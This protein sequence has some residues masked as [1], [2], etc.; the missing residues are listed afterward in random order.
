MVYVYGYLV[1][2]LM[3]YV[4]YLT[5]F[6]VEEN[7]WVTLIELI[8]GSLMTIFLPILLL[9]RF[10]LKKLAVRK[11]KRGI[12]REV[13]YLKDIEDATGIKLNFSGEW[14]SIPNLIKILMGK[15]KK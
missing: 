1:V 12:G 5:Y 3:F 8:I 10:T 2:A 13:I 4:G 6:Y 14:E 7:S 15:P 11:M 9:F